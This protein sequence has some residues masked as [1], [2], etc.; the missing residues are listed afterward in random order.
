MSAIVAGGCPWAATHAAQG[1]LTGGA[2]WLSDIA[3]VN[4]AILRPSW[5]SR[6]PAG[7]GGVLEAN[8]VFSFLLIRQGRGLRDRRIART[9]SLPGFVRQPP[10][11]YRVAAKTACKLAG[12]N[13]SPAT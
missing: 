2:R 11:R 3:V 7:R 5:R 9:R 13:E 4:G 1:P 12:N 8:G 6:I 10:D